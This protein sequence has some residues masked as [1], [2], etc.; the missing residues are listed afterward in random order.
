M[1]AITQN[2]YL[3]RSKNWLQLLGLTNPEPI[4]R[5]KLLQLL[6]I[7]LRFRLSIEC[8]ADLYSSFLSSSADQLIVS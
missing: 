4:V 3:P 1:V 5:Q 2:Q 6:L 7:P 8:I